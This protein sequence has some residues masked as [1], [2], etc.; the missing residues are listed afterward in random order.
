M[1]CPPCNQ[2]SARITDVLNLSFDLDLDRA[3]DLKQ[4][5]ITKLAK[6]TPRHWAWFVVGALLL[7]GFVEVI[8]RY[9]SRLGRSDLIRVK[10]GSDRSGC[11]LSTSHFGYGEPGL[12]LDRCLP[13]PVV[14]LVGTQGEIAHQPRDR[15]GGRTKRSGPLRTYPSA[16]VRRGRLVHLYGDQDRGLVDAHL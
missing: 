16:Y 3:R 2:A 5:V 1:S 7:A 4:V 11:S 14:P 15:Q 9:V 8:E 10:S 12:T 13:L 6:L